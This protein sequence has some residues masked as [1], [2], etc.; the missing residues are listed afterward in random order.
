MNPASRFHRAVLLGQLL[1]RALPIELHSPR[2]TPG[3]RQLAT[4]RAAKAISGSPPDRKPS[5]RFICLVYV[6][7]IDVPAQPLDVRHATPGKARVFYCFTM[8][9]SAVKTVCFM[10]FVQLK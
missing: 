7:Y 4:Y 1:V 10:L 2:A 8:S 3:S 9:E 5:P 6:P